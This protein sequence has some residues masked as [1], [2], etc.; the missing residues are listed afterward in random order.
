MNSG[1]GDVE[2]EMSLLVI[3]LYIFQ[4]QIKYTRKQ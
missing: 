3:T 1:H 4:Q 2:I